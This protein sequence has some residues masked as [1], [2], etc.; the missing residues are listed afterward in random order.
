MRKRR[1]ILVVGDSFCDVNA[2]PLPRLPEWGRNVVSPERILAQPGGAALNVACN[3]QRL[4]GDTA[5]YSGIGRDAFGDLLRVHLD[6]LGLT[7]AW[8]VAADSDEDAPTGVCMVLS[9]PD[10]RAFCSHFGVSDAF[11]ASALVADGAALLRRLG[12][13]HVH[14]A[15]YFSCA[16]LRKT[17]P[18][19]LLAAREV[20]ATTSLDT[21]NDASGQWGAVDGLPPSPGCHG[22]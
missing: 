17:L 6:S 9:G 18:R 8:D 4:R 20:G 13:C 15:G 14:C 12:P 21:N 10:D 16:A 2:G 19:L 22:R 5:L 3:L 7:L 1:T 11:D